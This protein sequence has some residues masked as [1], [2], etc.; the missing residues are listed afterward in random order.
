[1]KTYETTGKTPFARFKQQRWGA[2]G[3]GIEWQL[4]FDE[5]LAI[6]KESGHFAARGKRAG[7]YVMGRRGD[8][9]PYSKDNVYIC[10]FTQNVA[11]A[12]RFDPSKH[13][14]KIRLGEGRG[15]T[16][17]PRGRK[18][19][20]VVLS[21]KY[22]GVFATPAEAEVA[23]QRAVSEIRVSHGANFSAA[24]PLNTTQLNGEAL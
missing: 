19:Y 5:W 18:R 13:P 24:E 22:I 10:L 6:W 9:G 14:G 2:S 7:Q 17:L 8:V 20:Q 4:T 11:D 23:Y 15:W 3:R 16:L 12:F 21:K 1:M